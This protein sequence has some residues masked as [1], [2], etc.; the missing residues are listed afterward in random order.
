MLIDIVKAQ[1]NKLK[2]LNQQ[3]NDNEEVQNQRACD[4]EVTQL[5][6]A[7]WA[8]LTTYAK[9]QQTLPE[10]SFCW[11]DQL[12]TKVKRAVNKLKEINDDI[13]S[14]KNEL[15]FIKGQ[16]NDIAR[17]AKG[18]WDTFYSKTASAVNARLQILRRFELDSND[19]DFL[20]K[21]LAEGKEWGMLGTNSENYTNI[22][23]IDSFQR[24]VSK[25]NQEFDNLQIDEE[26]DNFI[27]K[28]TAGT[29]GINDLT[30]HVLQW[31]KD[32][33][34][35]NVFQVKFRG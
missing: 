21:N 34:F 17:S 9:A 16:V 22:P 29:A 2:K 8:Q 26:I 28:V 33:K 23:R 32:N 30:D 10:S 4:K 5:I 24:A 15:N 3:V 19:L 20:M 27:H 6:T 31:I 14:D 18:E 35:N 13:P 7:V 12:V 1:N 11:S 25:V